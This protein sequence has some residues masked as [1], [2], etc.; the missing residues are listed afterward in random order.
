MEDAQQ[1]IVDRAD[2]GANEVVLDG[3]VA[4]PLVEGIPRRHASDGE[5]V[6]ATAPSCRG[7]SNSSPSR[8]F[9]T[10]AL[11]FHNTQT[12]MC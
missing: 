5:I 11:P 4:E 6:S 8:W 3:G 9:S 1:I 12:M 2:A 10:V 7:I